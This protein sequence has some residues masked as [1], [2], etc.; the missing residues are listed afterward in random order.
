MLEPTGVV[1]RLAVRLRRLE[2][3]AFAIYLVGCCY[4]SSVMPLLCGVRWF[5]FILHDTQA[6]DRRLAVGKTGSYST[7]F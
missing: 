5:A 3:G 6:A 7:S 4:W 2:R 1:L